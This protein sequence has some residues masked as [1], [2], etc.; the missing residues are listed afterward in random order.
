M[1]NLVT[2]FE[3]Q[4]FKATRL[5][6]DCCPEFERIKYEGI[7]DWLILLTEV[8]GGYANNYFS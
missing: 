7:C 3:V 2:K 1:L 5:A 4:I 8:P 6:A